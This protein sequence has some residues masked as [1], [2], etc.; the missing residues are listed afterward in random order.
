MSQEALDV[1]IVPTAD[2]H[3]SEYIAP[4]W[5]CREKLTG[6]TGSAGTAVVTQQEA[7][8]WTDSRYWLQAED[9]LRDSGFTLM[10]DGAEGVPSIEEWIT[11]HCGTEARIGAPAD[12]AVN[13]AGGLK[14]CSGKD[15]FS[16]IWTD[17]PALPAEPIVAQDE[18][19]TGMTAGEKLEALKRVLEEQKVN[20]DDVFV[21]NDLSDT[22]W[23]LN[24]RGTDVDYNPV[25]LSYLCYD[26]ATEK[27]L[28]YTHGSTLTPEAAERLKGAGVEV[29]PY[30]DVKL[31]ASLP[32]LRVC[33]ETACWGMW[34]AGVGTFHSPVEMWRAVK[35]E[36]EQEG[37][38]RAMLQDG[39]AMVKFLRWLDERMAKEEEVTELSIDEKLTALR[40]EQEDFEQLSFGTIAAYG[41]HGAIVHYEADEHT[42]VR[43]PAH[44]L[45]LLDSGGQYHSGT[46]DLTRTIAMG[47]LTQE[48]REVYTLVMK[49]HLRLEHMKFPVGTTGLQLDT[50]ARQ[51]LW[52]RGYDFGHGTGHGVGAHGCVHEGPHQIRKDLRACTLVPFCEGM[53][54]TDEPGVYVEGRFGVRIENTLLC[55]KAEETPYGK[56][57]QFEALTLCPYDL[58]AIDRSL[59]SPYEI[60]QINTYH[61]RVRKAIM[62]LLT[63]DDDRIWL[64]RAT[65][66]V[67]SELD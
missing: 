54:V 51:D 61:E 35:S 52:A 57:L 10:K 12:M 62:P 46:T 15:A 18:Q 53:T 55:Q 58:R 33:Q 7:L 9:Q 2:A 21:V 34:R 63:D 22:A 44:G 37:L 6:F 48:E 14:I 49:G 5:A 60:E 67:E 19:W 27:F 65:A 30:E 24:L 64:A 45:L 59:L 8:L 50:A 3:N 32:H 42:N 17:R 38:R 43:I 13:L 23:L 4:H 39:V 41:R 26:S 28:L 31:L 40:A 56:F 29:K 66:A 36:A 1:Y 25:F 47:H 11:D 20:E 16:E